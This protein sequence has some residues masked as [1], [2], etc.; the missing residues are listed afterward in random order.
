MTGFF[1]WLI[2]LVLKVLADWGLDLVKK[3]AAKQL[4]YKRIED[5]ALAV[6]NAANEAQQAAGES[7]DVP[8]E[9]EAKLRDAARRLNSNV[10]N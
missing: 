3:E 4:D 7:G 8:P 1:E 6:K 2:G 5:E 10:F 9:I